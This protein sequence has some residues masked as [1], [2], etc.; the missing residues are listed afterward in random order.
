MIFRSFL[1][2]ALC[3]AVAAGA[4][5]A[6]SAQEPPPEFELPDVV[7]PGRRAQPAA[8]SPASVS[9]L[10]SGELRR[11]GVRTVGEAVAHLPET[12]ARAYGGAGGLITGSIRGSSA[13]QVLVLLDGVPLNGVFGGTVD[14]GTIP[15][16]DVERIEVLRGPFSAAYGSGALGGV[17][18]I[19]TRR[20]AAPSLTLGAGSYGGVTVG[21]SGGDGPRLSLRYEVSDGARPNSDL[22]S[23]SV[24]LRL[25][26]GEAAGRWDLSLFGAAASRGA[27][28]STLFPSLLAR[29]DDLR[30]AGALTFERERGATTDR[31]RLSLHTE[32]LSFRDPGYGI[33]DRHDAAAWAGEWQRVAKRSGG[34]VLTWGAD[35]QAQSLSSTSVGARSAATGALY[36]QDDRPAGPRLLLSTGLRADLHSAYASQI[37]PRAGLVYFARPDLRL[38]LAAGRT[39]RG[40]TMAELYYPFDGFAV[41]N[42]SLRPE[43]AWSVDGGLE[44]QVSPRAVVRMTAFWSDVRDLIV[45]VPDA[46]FVFAPQNVGSARVLGGS[47]EYNG[48]IGDRWSLRASSTWMAATDAQS[49]LDL[50]NRPRHHGTLSLTHTFPGGLGLTATALYVGE[51]FADASGAIALPSYFTAG[52][53][54]SRDLGSGLRLRVTIQNL[55]DALY[56][57]VVGYPAPGRTALVEVVVRR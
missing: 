27:P 10:T 40:P 37:S 41:G 26:G 11:M 29:Q 44:Y 15:I 19:T 38:R 21:F 16:D 7:S 20:R 33:D 9:V 24:S 48:A 4:A 39:F 8:A 22:R 6:G 54:A 55:F 52:L 23:G 49:G 42:P 43:H 51:R 57:P 47:L 35:L 18:S 46:M 2:L 5:P 25:G 45:W 1:A 13:E 12:V 56:E 28:G 36:V 3:A 17:I 50:P 53:T 14:L 30:I 34:G 32:G 31:L